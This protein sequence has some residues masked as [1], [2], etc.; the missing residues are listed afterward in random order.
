M[1]SDTLHNFPVTPAPVPA[2]LP[3]LRVALVGCGKTKTAHPA[4]AR[5]V[6]TGGLFVAARRY[7]E[8]AV[9]AGLYDA[10]YV[11]SAR[12]GILT[13]DQVVGP[14]E[15]TMG[16]KTV[17]QV[18]AWSNKVDAA[19]RCSS[20]GYG[21]WSAMGGRLAVDVLAGAA[22]AEPLQHLWATLPW[23]IGT[24]LAGLTMGDR[25]AWYKRSTLA[26]TGSDQ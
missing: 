24:P 3:P 23:T 12:H 11:L 5:R 19:F 16:A 22:Y 2:E 4:P 1:I 26:L 21:L 18:A 14:Y 20:P 10:W 6:Y 17:D 13:P 8:A 7:V 25:L 15:A 9:A